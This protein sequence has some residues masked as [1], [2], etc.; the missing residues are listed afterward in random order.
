[1]K[2]D[3]AG[4]GYCPGEKGTGMFFGEEEKL[5][6]SERCLSTF[7]NGSSAKKFRNY[8]TAFLPHPIS[9]IP[10]SLPALSFFIETFFFPPR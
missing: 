6:R 5:D 7:S 2:Y 3:Q 1:L 9:P 4:K 10:P 8:P